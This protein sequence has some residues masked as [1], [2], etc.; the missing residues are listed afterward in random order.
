[1]KT[2]N[3][4]FYETS[5][6]IKFEYPEYCPHCGESISPERLFVSN[7]EDYLSSCNARFTVTFRCSRS[8]CKKYFASEYIANETTSEAHLVDYYYRPPIKVKLPENIEKVSSMFV[9]IYSQATIAEQEM[10]DQIAGV[11]YRKAAEFLIKDYAVSKNPEDSENIKRIM[12]GKVISDYLSD[13]PKLQALSRSIAWI[14]NDETHYIRKHDN[15]DLQDLKR[16]ILATAQFIAADYDA[17][18]ALSFTSPN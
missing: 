15:K 14:G 7:S 9:E 5:R 16:F 8:D 12:L 11:G 1:M 6:Q 4:S 18:D 10:L 3:V 13:F 17:D 2:A